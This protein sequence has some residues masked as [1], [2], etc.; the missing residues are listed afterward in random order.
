MLKILQVIIN[1]EISKNQI[2]KIIHKKYNQ[3][4]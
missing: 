1:Q 4:D 3:A 2:V